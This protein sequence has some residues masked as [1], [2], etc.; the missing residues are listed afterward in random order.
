MPGGS[1]HDHW[2]LST[3]LLSRRGVLENTASSIVVV[4]FSA[5][6]GRGK[7]LDEVHSRGTGSS[8]ASRLF[9]GALIANASVMSV[10]TARN[11]RGVRTARFST[12][13][14]PLSSLRNTSRQLRK[15]PF[16]GKRSTIAR[17]TRRPL[18]FLFPQF[19]RDT[20]H[21]SLVSRRWW[22]DFRTSS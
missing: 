5:V 10:L 13:F 15:N 2:Q 8:T 22:R 18:P 9:G 20:S 21:F 19:F 3:C 11:E 1:C 14:R 7:I 17:V 4:T 16:L 6:R 12:P